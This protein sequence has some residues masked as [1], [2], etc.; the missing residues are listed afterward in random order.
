MD[1]RNQL[2]QQQQQQQSAASQTPMTSSSK[3]LKRDT[4]DLVTSDRPDPRNGANTT[5]GTAP[6]PPATEAERL[7]KEVLHKNEVFHLGSKGETLRGIGDYFAGR[8]RGQN[9]KGTLL[10]GLY[11]VAVSTV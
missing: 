9:A 3:R 8:V 4:V 11:R 2:P 5:N 7:R 1:P 6:Q 10:R